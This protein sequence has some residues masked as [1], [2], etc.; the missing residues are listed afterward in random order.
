VTLFNKGQFF[1]EYKTL[2]LKAPG[3]ASS[4]KTKVADRLALRG[5]N[6]VAFGDKN[7]SGSERWVMLGSAGLAIRS[8]PEGSESFPPGIIV[9]QSDI[10]EIFLLVSRGSPVTIQ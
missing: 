5:S 9:A 4:A 1:K 8:V 10:E 3:V 6:R 2:S 7:Y